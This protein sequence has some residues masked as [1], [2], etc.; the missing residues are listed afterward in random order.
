[1]ITRFSFSIRSGSKVRP[2]VLQHVHVPVLPNEVCENWHRRQGINI[3]IHDE[4]LCAGYERGGKDSCQARPFHSSPARYLF[5]AHGQCAATQYNAT[6][7]AQYNAT[8]V[9]LGRPPE[10]SAVRYRSNIDSCVVG[11]AVSYPYR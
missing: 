10:T 5:P 4:M 1:M 6:P 11:T 8:R 3:R 9:T 2:R 7:S